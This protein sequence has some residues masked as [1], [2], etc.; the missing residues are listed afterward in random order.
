MNSVNIRIKHETLIPTMPWSNVYH[1]AKHFETEI[2]KLIVKKSSSVKYV[3]ERKLCLKI[4]KK[5]QLEK[6]AA[7]MFLIWQ[8]ELCTPIIRYLVS[9]ISYECLS[10]FVHARHFW[11]S[12]KYKTCS[13]ISQY[14]MMPIHIRTVGICTY[15]CAQLTSMYVVWDEELKRLYSNR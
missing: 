14:A 6:I 8:I 9:L 4:T 1:S 3:C 10:K 13:Y 11:W 7:L 5:Y 12:N 2:Y 15:M